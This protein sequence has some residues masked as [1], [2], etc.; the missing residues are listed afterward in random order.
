VTNFD[1]L[2]ASVSPYL[3]SVQPIEEM[4]KAGFTFSGEIAEAIGRAKPAQ[5]T[6]LRCS[7]RTR[8]FDTTNS[9][10]V[11]GHL[12]G[13]ECLTIRNI[14]WFYPAARNSVVRYPEYSSDFRTILAAIGY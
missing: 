9:T 6:D 3:N 14:S 5:V 4:K 1:E 2:L 13:N 8:D 10:I 12:A 11:H 7:R